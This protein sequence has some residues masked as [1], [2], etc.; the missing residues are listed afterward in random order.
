MSLG[1]TPNIVILLAD[2]LGFS[3][4]GCYGSEIRTP[5]LDALARDGVTMSSFYNTARCSPSR[6]SLLTGL[7][8]HQTGIGILTGDT[9]PA[10]YSGDLDPR[11]PTLAELLRES[12]YL[13]SVIGKWH[14]ARDVRRPNAAWPTRRGFD[15]H[16]GPLG[17]ACSYFEPTTM[18]SGEHVIEVD[19]DDFYLTEELGV[20]AS[21]TVHDAAQEQRP[22]FLYLPFTAP[23]W[24]LHARPEE[25]ASYDGIYS[26]GWDEVRAGRLRAMGELGV[27]GD[28]SPPL[29]DR[30]DDVPS[31][32]DVADAD[33]QALRMQ[34]YA[35]Q[36][37]AMDTAIGQVVQALE[38]T[39][40]R[41]NTL[42]MFLSDNGG[43]AEEIPPGWAD[44]MSPRPYNVPGRTRGGQRVRKGNAPSV[45][46]G[47]RASF[48]SYGKPWANVSNTPFREYK[49]WVHE[50]GI[51]TPLIAHWPDGGL[52]HGWDHSPHQ[53]TDIV[54]TLLEAVGRPDSRKPVES[55][56]HVDA[57][58]RRGCSMLPSWRD[59]QR[60][61]DDHPLFFEHEGNAAIRHG[62]W[63]GVRKHGEPWELY[64]L[65]N[66]RTETR[67]LAAA[68]PGIL[69]EL[70]SAWTD[71]ALRCGVRD[72]SA[73]LAQRTERRGRGL[74]QDFHSAVASTD[75]SDTAHRRAE[76]RT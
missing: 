56:E 3:D 39:A 46:P 47:G 1:T 68:E 35:A 30:D 34:V 24:P 37:S 55:A 64:D 48:A 44:E 27:F 51:S 6:A 5:H 38:E 71:W 42:I 28:R 40:Q 63:K 19:D 67:D 69:S 49:H 16:W 65:A 22:F 33:W 11:C 62:R 23:H 2:D 75:A 18:A 29:S 17:G 14:L 53:L 59:R 43:C 76:K 52:E 57:V 54:P 66:D 21:R 58:E 9:R 32:D 50:G 12:G 8:P 10:G 72:R 20:R 36:V 45:V 4:I 41:A 26:R 74:I 61:P 60:A 15:T 25:I 13:T 7:D 31:W 70:T 73:I